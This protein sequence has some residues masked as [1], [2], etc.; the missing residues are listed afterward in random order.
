MDK[1]NELNSALTVRL[2]NAFTKDQIHHWAGSLADLQAMGMK[3][4]DVFPQGM[5][6]PDV[7]VMQASVP[8]TELGTAIMQLQKHPHLRR[9]EVFP[10]GIPK[11]DTWRV[12][13]GMGLK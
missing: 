10:W 13:V 7:L 11:Q 4:D 6:A 12:H 1:L 2:R 5:P 8:L 9:I 3:V